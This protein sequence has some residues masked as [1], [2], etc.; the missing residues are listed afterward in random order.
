[1]RPTWLLLLLLLVSGCYTEGDGFAQQQP[2]PPPVDPNTLCIDPGLTRCSGQAFQICTNGRWVD[3]QTCSGQAPVCDPINGCTE[4]LPETTFCSDEEIW[5]CDADGRAARTHTCDPTQ[6]CIFGSCW[7]RCEQAEGTNSYLGCRFLAVPTANVLH[8]DFSSDFAVV[9]GNPD[10]LTP[11]EVSIR[12]GGA[13]VA[14]GVVEARST[15]AFELDIV[16]ELNSYDASVRVEGAAFEVATTLPVAAYQ[17]NPLHFQAD[18]GEYSFTNDASLLLPEHVLSGTYR[19]MSLPT[20]GIGEFP[21]Q[22]DF[23]PGFVA[24]AATEDGT[25]VELTS[26]AFTLAGEFGQLAPGESTVVSLDRGDVV[27][28]FSERP[29]ASTSANVC[30]E[31]GG[32]LAGNGVNASC[33]LED[34][35]DLTGTLISADKDVAVWSGHVCTFVPFDQWACDHLEEGMFPVETWGRSL[36]ITAPTRPEGGGTA[37]TQLRVL[38]HEDGTELSFTGDVHDAVSLEAGGFVEFTAIEDFVLESTR[39]VTVTQ[40]L[41]GQNAISSNAGDPAMGSGIP[42]TQW[43]DEYDFLVPETYT[44]NYINLVAPTGT[45]VYLDGVELNGWEPISGTDFSVLRWEIDAG[46]HRLESVGDVGFGLTSYG[47]AL[48]T[49]Y[50]YPGGMNFLRGTR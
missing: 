25:L 50:L 2:P 19:A 1:M 34:R 13:L 35:G 23:V 42:R 47:Y 33:L 9:I 3:Q 28:V 30:T 36:V 32:T 7:D 20:I 49:S 5:T 6:E 11:A 43:R 22:A 29:T 38:A 10:P 46:S 8:P 44:S 16:P 37:P 39:P 31:L 4:C 27:Q 24:V 18:S 26:S 40:T 17:Y 21:G 48:Y 14:S 15:A 45:A 41:L 12:R